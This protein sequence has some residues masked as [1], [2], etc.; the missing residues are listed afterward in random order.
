MDLSLL[1]LLLIAINSLALIYVAVR[2][3]QNGKTHDI[4]SNYLNQ[5]Y[6]Y[7]LSLVLMWVIFAISFSPSLF[8]NEPK[9]DLANG[10]IQ[11]DARFSMFTCGLPFILFGLYI[12]YL[13]F[14]YTHLGESKLEFFLYIISLGQQIW[15]AFTSAEPGYAAF[16][17]AAWYTVGF[18]VIRWLGLNMGD[19]LKMHYPSAW[20]GHHTWLRS[21]AGDISYG[22]Y[23]KGSRMDWL[24]KNSARYDETAGFKFTA[25]NAAGATI[26]YAIWTMLYWIFFLVV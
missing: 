1:P 15:F 6:A 17:L 16:A 20:R 11:L 10:G 13:F 5:I 26:V 24:I 25:E 3:Y 12:L 7:I 22:W 14:K 2:N 18:F 21:K 9:F 8:A 19:F 23:G 4:L